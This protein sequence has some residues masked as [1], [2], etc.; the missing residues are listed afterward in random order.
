MDLLEQEIEREKKFHLEGAD[1]SLQEFNASIEAGRIADIPIGKKVTMIAFDEAKKAIEELQAK[2]GRGLYGKYLVHIRKIPSDV[3]AVI[4]LRTIITSCFSDIASSR[5]QTVCRVLGSAIESEI[6]IDCINKDKPWYIKKVDKQVQ[7]EG[8]RSVHNI[9]RK[10]RTAALDVG[11]SFDNWS[12]E[13]RVQTAKLVLEALYPLGLFVW[14]KQKHD[15][16]IQHY[17]E[18]SEDLQKFFENGKDHLL[19]KIT[20]PVMI[21]PPCDWTSYNIGGYYTNELSARAPMMRLRSMPKEFRRWIISN[22]REG[23][24][25]VAKK[26]MNIA[27]KVPYRVNKKV[28]DLA[29]RA[30]AFPQGVLGLPPHGS[31]PKPVFP[32]GGNFD[33]ETATEEETQTFLNWKAEMKQWYTY[34]NT[35][36]GRKIGI[37][38][39]LNEMT[40]LQDVERWYCPTFL[41]WRGRLYFRS[42]LNPQA[43]DVIK[44]CIDFAD[45][46]PLGEEG[47]YW[48]KFHVANCCGYDK[49]SPDLRVQWCDEHWGEIKKFIDDPL[50]VEPPEVD[51]AFTLYQAGLELSEALAL[52]DPR[53]Y[54]SGVPVALDATCS[55]LQH[56]SAML[57]DEVGGG[58]TNLIDNGGDQKSDIYSEVARITLSLLHNYTTDPVILEY[59]NR[60]GFARSLAKRPVMTYVYSA[61]L[62][63]CI[64]YVNEALVQSGDELPEGYNSF[65]MC[66]PAGKA[67]RKGVELSVPKAKE[68]MEYL[69]TLVK[70]NPS[71]PLRWVNPVGVPVVN[72]TETSVVKRIKIFSMGISF[73]NLQVY[74]PEYAM[75]KA[76]NGISP[77]FIHSMDSAHLCKVL[78]ALDDDVLPIHDSF[79]VHASDVTR[80]RETLLN[81]F[82][83]MYTSYN[84][85]LDIIEYVDTGNTQPVQPAKGNLDINLVKSSRY[86]FC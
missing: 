23:K 51:T 33:K 68:G 71:A 10:Y 8:S 27:Q 73:M 76:I 82:V 50:N 85:M 59:W 17:I 75:R 34:E 28:L 58:L 41:D 70:T 48:L 60:V 62:R 35:R 66:V 81:E 65:M 46:K 78:V 84:S 24:A 21:A 77:N 45:R 25:D 13:E 80:L 64:D 79:A 61:T 26:A 2:R 30:M 3:L 40:E 9:A 29:R 16:K 15:G 54:L 38:A 19:A 53:E 67:L 43:S 6:L 63:S 49:A 12:R 36:V 39:R 11:L 7:A 44:G 42:T 1:R 20:Y 4:A 31:K 18:P 72:F 14:S 69:Q 32:F 56:Y 83:N 57:R 5:L 22:V 74:D 37:L 86:T 52:P 55:G 47:L